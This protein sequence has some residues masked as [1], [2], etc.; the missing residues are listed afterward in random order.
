MSSSSDAFARSVKSGRFFA[1]WRSSNLTLLGP[2]GDN[3]SQFTDADRTSLSLPMGGVW[4]W[5]PLES[6]AGGI[7]LVSGGARRKST[8]GSR[9]WKI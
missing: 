2:I 7:P 6:E 9:N 5:V 3:F 1:Y 8:F 4:E